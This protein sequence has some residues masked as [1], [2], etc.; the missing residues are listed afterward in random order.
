MGKVFFSEPRQSGIQYVS[1]IAW[2]FDFGKFITI[3]DVSLQ[4]MHIA[5]APIPSFCSQHGITH[6]RLTK[7]LFPWGV[8]WSSSIFLSNS[9]IFL[10]SFQANRR[11]RKFVE[12]TTQ[13]CQALAWLAITISDIFC[14]EFDGLIFHFPLLYPI[15]HYSRYAPDIVIFWMSFWGFDFD[16]CQSYHNT[17]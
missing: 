7:Y 4:A 11:K 1:V 17:R 8:E 5:C 12:R 13:K 14:A 9:P 16:F 6:E 15:Y 10:P 3:T 2:V